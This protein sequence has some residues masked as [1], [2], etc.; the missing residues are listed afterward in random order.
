MVILVMFP[1]MESTASY[2]A[3][4]TQTPS[5][6]ACKLEAPPST[7]LPRMAASL[8]FTKQVWEGYLAYDVRHL[9]ADASRSAIPRLRNY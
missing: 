3:C 5:M 2:C 8:E 6:V 7:N 4:A 9:Y 1:G